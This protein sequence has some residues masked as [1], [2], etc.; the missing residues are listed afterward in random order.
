[1]PG[2][3][4]IL[5]ENTLMIAVGA[6]SIQI[7]AYHN[8]TLHSTQN[9]KIGALRLREVFGALENERLD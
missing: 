3:D 9:I 1:M 8:Q 2:I 6:G 7:T 4:D 5:K